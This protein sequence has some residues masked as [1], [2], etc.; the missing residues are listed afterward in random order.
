MTVAKGS[1]NIGPQ[2]GKVL[3]NVYKDGMAAKMGHDLTLEATSWSGKADINPDDPSA[4]SVQVTIDAGSLEVVEG[5]GGAKPL[6]DNDKRDIKKNITDK[7]L[8]D[9]SISFESTGVSGSTPR[10]QLKGDLTI[11]GQTQPVNLDLNVDDSGHAKGTA[12]F[13][14]TQFGLKPFSAM[15]GALKVKDSVDITIDVQL[16]TA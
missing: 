1:H 5:K 11:N 9:T 2:D 4:S 16:P 12:S 13:K 6:S 10:L 15:M 7:V 8:R 3:V 14:Q